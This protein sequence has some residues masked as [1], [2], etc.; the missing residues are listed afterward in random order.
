ML[1]YSFQDPNWPYLQ[2]LGLLNLEGLLLYITGPTNGVSTISLTYRC[3]LTGYHLYVA[4]P[5]EF[6]DV[7]YI[8]LG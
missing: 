4:G 1:R 5:I 6:S 7:T 8:C 2:V 3:V